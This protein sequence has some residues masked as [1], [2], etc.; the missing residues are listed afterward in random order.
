MNTLIIHPKDPTT[1]FLRPIY[2]DRDVMTV[3]RGKATRHETSVMIDKC[4]TPMM[5]GHGSPAGLWGVGQFARSFAIDGYF[6]QNLQQKVGVYIWC[7]ADQFVRKHKLS[8]FYTGMF[9]S[10][11]CEAWTCGVNAFRHEVTE[12]NDLF[13]ELMG[14]ATG[15]A[16]MFHLAMTEY[17][18]LA[19][20]NPVAAYNLDRM[21]F[22]PPAGM[23]H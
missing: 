10:E 22:A 20:H 2:E 8:G 16:D 15:P 14:E 6:I 7:N 9:I 12:S 5:M 19:E 23:I 3:V 1:E 18:E 13:A 11:S 4:Q 17:A 21:Y